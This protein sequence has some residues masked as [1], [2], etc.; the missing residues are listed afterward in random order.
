MVALEHGALQL[1]LP[2]MRVQSLFGAGFQENIYFILYIF[3]SPLKVGHCFDVC[4]LVLCKALH[5]PMLH[6]THV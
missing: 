5:P 4:I 3:F 1:S 2:V 6:L